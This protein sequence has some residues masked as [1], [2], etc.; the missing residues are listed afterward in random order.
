MNNLHVDENSLDELAKAQLPKVQ[1]YAEAN[2]LRSI[3][4]Q[5]PNWYGIDAQG[6]LVIIPHSAYK[7]AFPGLSSL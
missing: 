6:N 2:D 7:P 5:S 4:K 1:A 3:S